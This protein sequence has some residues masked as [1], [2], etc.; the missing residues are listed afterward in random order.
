LQTAVEVTSTHAKCLQ[1]DLLP[2]STE[3]PLE[4]RDSMTP[5][6]RG[7]GQN[8]L[9]KPTHNL[10]VIADEGLAI[11]GEVLGQD[12]QSRQTEPGSELASA[13]RVLS[14]STN[15]SMKS[16]RSPAR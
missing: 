15:L 13:A 7:L 14:E 4:Q 6:R 2:G 11:W 12:E 3:Y 9:S 5:V 16:V 1:I 10:L 8:G